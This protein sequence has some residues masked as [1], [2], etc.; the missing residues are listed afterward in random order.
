MANLIV[1]VL[2]VLT[3]F[4][5]AADAQD[6]ATQQALRE[7]QQLLT[8]PTE[9]TKALSTD[10]KAQAHDAKTRAVLGNNTEGAY[11]ISSQL[12]ETLV[13]QSGGDAGKMQ[14]LVNKLMANPQSLEQYLTPAQRE[15]IRKMASDVEAKKG[16]APNGGSGN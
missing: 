1:L 6:P 2:I 13:Q 12:M 9:R 14:E 10:P 11:Q 3:S 7:T 5:N 8:N 15:Q 16:H 4:A